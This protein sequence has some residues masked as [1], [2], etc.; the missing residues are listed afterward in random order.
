MY[1]FSSLF[2]VKNSLPIMSRHAKRSHAELT[3]ALSLIHLSS[4]P[5]P[6]T[7]EENNNHHHNHQAFQLKNTHH[8]TSNS[9][10]LV[11]FA[12]RQ[13]DENDTDDID[14]GGDNEIDF[15][16]LEQRRMHNVNNYIMKTA[17]AAKAAAAAK[18]QVK[19]SCHDVRDA[20]S[21]MSGL[22]SV[23]NGNVTVSEMA[24][25]DGHTTITQ[26]HAQ[27]TCTSM[28]EES[29]DTNTRQIQALLKEQHSA[30]IQAPTI[31]TFTKQLSSG[32]P[33][34]ESLQLGATAGNIE[35]MAMDISTNTLKF[36]DLREDFSKLNVATKFHL[37]KL[38]EGS[39]N[40]SNSP[41]N[42]QDLKINTTYNGI[43]RKILENEVEENN[44]KL[45]RLRD[46]QLQVSS[47][48]GIV[49]H[50]L[51]SF[52]RQAVSI[53]SSNINIE[54]FEILPESQRSRHDSRV[55]SQNS[56]NQNSH[57]QH[58]FIDVNSILN[59]NNKG[60]NE[61]NVHINNETNDQLLQKLLGGS[62]SS[63]ASRTSCLVSPATNAT[64]GRGTS[65][66]SLNQINVTHHTPKPGTRTRNANSLGSFYPG[67]GQNGGTA[68]TFT[69]NELKDINLREEI[70]KVNTG[71]ANASH[72]PNIPTLTLSDLQSL[73]LITNTH[74]VQ[75]AHLQSPGNTTMIRNFNSLP[76][77]SY[78]NSAKIAKG[79]GEN[80]Q[81]AESFNGI[82]SYAP[83]LNF[84]PTINSQPQ[85]RSVGTKAHST[86]I[87]SNSSTS[88]SNS[89]NNLLLT[90]GISNLGMSN[91]INPG[92]L[93]TI[94][95][96]GNTNFGEV[97]TA[98]S[99]P[100]I[101]NSTC[102]STSATS[103]I[104]L[105]DLSTDFLKQFQYFPAAMN[106]DV[107]T[108]QTSNMNFTTTFN[109]Q[110]PQ[111]GSQYSVSVPKFPQV[112][113]PSN[114]VHFPVLPNS[115]TTSTKNKGKNSNFASTGVRRRGESKK[116]R[117]Q[118]GIENKN[119]WCKACIWKKACT[120]FPD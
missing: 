79:S 13:E 91:M 68:G 18:S 75:R 66:H 20:A 57:S 65:G 54:N 43:D 39:N 83:P 74:N 82:I 76:T 104:Q 48:V 112:Q 37:Q 59:N 7:N 2:L 26:N 41:S 45:K 30:L 50:N 87:A 73:N 38:L 51:N 60:L 34:T 103:P 9:D 32:N 53:P 1:I 114:R 3:A 84:S 40:P 29:V 113:V 81:K 77:G 92:G 100:G 116:C 49:N 85:A 19:A 27:N 78:Q 110:T 107:A 71:S 93:P 64:S 14:I 24:D 55:G 88:H 22:D 23:S 102:N 89:H 4:S 90:N 109:H 52:G 16:T 47:G 97:G 25:T 42:I 70:I 21:L 96:A 69:I 106:V 80:H 5:Q 86:G 61:L 94:V 63:L 46:D 15:E 11:P 98:A 58:N 95:S 108:G 62:T 10:G 111:I 118:F 6:L 36:E 28:T 99:G 17:Q 12:V 56:V 119:Q 115:A 33:M 31:P 67:N 44:R 117:K 120:R 8:Y 101:T 35:G 105:P 72:E